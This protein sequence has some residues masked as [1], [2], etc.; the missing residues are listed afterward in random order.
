LHYG[1]G[2]HSSHPLALIPY[3]ENFVIVII[4]ALAGDAP[5]IVSEQILDIFE[6]NLEKIR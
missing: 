4:E 6:E 2:C 1:S 5:V 3:R